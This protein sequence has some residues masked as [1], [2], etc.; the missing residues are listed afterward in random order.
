MC[1]CIYIYIS[2]AAL[3]CRCHYLHIIG[4]TKA[5][6]GKDHIAKLRTQAFLIP[7]PILILLN[8]SASTHSSIIYLKPYIPQVC[9]KNFP[10]TRKCKDGNLPFLTGMPTTNNAQSSC[11]LQHISTYVGVDIA[12]VYMDS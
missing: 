6:S 7:K 5:Q 9:I 11:V 2:S 1:M 3:S 12:Q 8:H 10:C 4:E